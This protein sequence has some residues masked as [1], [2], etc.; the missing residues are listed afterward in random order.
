M[1]PPCHPRARAVTLSVPVWHSSGCPRHP[2]AGGDCG[3][4]REVHQLDGL[5][6]LLPC[7][8]TPTQAPGRLDGAAVVVWRGSSRRFPIQAWQSPRSDPYNGLALIGVAVTIQ[9]NHRWT[10]INTDMDYSKPRSSMARIR[11]PDS[12]P[13]R[14]EARPESGPQNLCS[15]VS[16]CGSLLHECGSATHQL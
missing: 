1:P 5:I 9:Y 7:D 12:D 15:S 14:N 10:Q 6:S 11:S 13:K 16:T 2:K 3:V 4:S 8:C